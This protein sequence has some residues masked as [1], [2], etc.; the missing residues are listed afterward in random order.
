MASQDVG[1]GRRCLQD[2]AACHGL[3]RA[4]PGL[5]P[6]PARD[7]VTRGE[8]RGTSKREMAIGDQ[9][10]YSGLAKPDIRILCRE[11]VRPGNP[12]GG[13]G[14]GS[15]DVGCYAFALE[16]QREREGGRKAFLVS[17]S[18]SSGLPHLGTEASKTRTI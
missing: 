2:P 6:G 15:F 3:N 8:S 17:S 1:G 7:A 18:S 9:E 12:S 13:G 14:G 16:K 11:S 5:E 10:L 4:W